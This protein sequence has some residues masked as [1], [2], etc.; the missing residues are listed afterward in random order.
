MIFIDVRKLQ[1]KYHKKN[2]TFQKAD[3][4]FPK[5]SQNQQ[6]I[7]ELTLQ[8]EI[9]SNID[10]RDGKNNMYKVLSARNE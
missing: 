4:E 5:H 7:I 1:R 2:E 6:M 8:P 10:E 3:K 9:R